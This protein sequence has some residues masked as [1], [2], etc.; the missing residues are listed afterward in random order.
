MGYYASIGALVGSATRP[1][2]SQLPNDVSLRNRDP[3]AWL[4]VLRQFHDTEPTVWNRLFALEQGR[5]LLAMTAIDVTTRASISN[6]T[7]LVRMQTLLAKCL[8][9]E[10][11]LSANATAHV[12]VAI[13][14]MRASRQPAKSF[15]N[16]AT[17]TRIQKWLQDRT[18]TVRPTAARVTTSV[19]QHEP[20]IHVWLGGPQPEKTFYSY[21]LQP[22]K[23]AG[24]TA[25]RNDTRACL[26]SYMQQNDIELV[27]GKALERTLADGLW[28][29]LTTMWQA[30]QVPQ[31]DMMTAGPRARIGD[32]KGRHI[33]VAHMPTPMITTW[34]F[35]AVER[36]VQD[37]REGSG[38]VSRV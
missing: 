19:T 14:R 25:Q 2:E 33:I 7:P 22:V 10:G 24:E 27:K 3:E 16:D 12:G 29:S 26:R 1:E 18:V 28:R 4:T 36:T 38:T 37:F 20:T 5:S 15:Y 21:A 9:Q 11:T 13:Q 23:H 8:A 31:T 6:A 17:R 35:E 34:Q 30:Q 32:H